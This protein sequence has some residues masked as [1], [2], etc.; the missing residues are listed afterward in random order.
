MKSD[1]SFGDGVIS[2]ANIPAV[3]LVQALAIVVVLGPLTERQS[4]CQILEAFSKGFR[5]FETTVSCLVRYE[6]CVHISRGLKMQTVCGVGVSSEARVGGRG[7]Q[8]EFGVSTSKWQP[9]AR[10]SGSS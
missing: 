1:P 10:F 8:G 3:R 2:G 7:G 5:N 4:D 6:S 9:K